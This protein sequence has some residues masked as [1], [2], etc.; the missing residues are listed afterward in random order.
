MAG[1]GK[2]QEL[3]V[4]TEV[5]VSTEETGQPEANRF[6]ENWREIV[7]QGVDAL[8]WAE[9]MLDRELAQ[10]SETGPLLASIR[11]ISGL[12]A[13]LRDT[14]EA[15]WEN[16]YARVSLTPSDLTILEDWEHRGVSLRNSRFD[17]LGEARQRAPHFRALRLFL[18]QYLK[19]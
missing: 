2:I 6:P 15:E 10:S 1:R 19:Q 7:K 17:R 12:A 9:G 14:R 5:I 3:E 8:T 18:E 11:D 16:G 13:R 4:R